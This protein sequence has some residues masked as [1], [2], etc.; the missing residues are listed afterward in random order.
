[1]FEAYDLFP[2][3]DCLKLDNMD[4]VQM[5]MDKIEPWIE[6]TGDGINFSLNA[7]N[8]FIGGSV[9]VVG[10]VIAA[11]IKKGQ[12][13]DRL[14]CVYCD[15]TGQILC[16]HCLGPPG[17]LSYTDDDGKLVL[18]EDCANCEKTGSV[19]CINCQGSGLSVPD[20]FLKV[21]GDEEVGFTEEDYIGL[22]DETPI[23]RAKE[24]TLKKPLQTTSFDG[25]AD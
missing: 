7:V 3:V 17:V 23:P 1:M 9:G 5:C 10:T 15:G 14:T 18:G 6:L 11:Q 13:K 21:L 16:G 25:L 20:D 4:A 19:V 22:F 12:V 2:V 8:G 24:P